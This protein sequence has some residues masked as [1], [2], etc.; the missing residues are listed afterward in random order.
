MQVLPQEKPIID[1]KWNTE[2]DRGMYHCC[3]GR[4]SISVIVTPCYW[5]SKASSLIQ[6]MAFGL[7]NSSYELQQQPSTIVHKTGLRF[8]SVSSFLF[9]TTTKSIKY[10]L[11]ESKVFRR[12]WK[13]LRC[14]WIIWDYTLAHVSTEVLR[15]LYKICFE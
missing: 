9:L 11:C 5:Q 6:F 14:C 12:S 7:F 1:R 2:S 8:T 10:C 3:Q 4:L 13:L 15:N